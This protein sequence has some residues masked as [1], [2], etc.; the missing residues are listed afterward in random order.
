MAAIVFT[1]TVPVHE[2]APDGQTQVDV[3]PTDPRQ[4][5]EYRPLEYVS[6]STLNNVDQVIGAGLDQSTGAVSRCTGT[7]G[8]GSAQPGTM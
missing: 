7:G 3:M 5:A 4:T 6:G 2:P 8:E 1:P